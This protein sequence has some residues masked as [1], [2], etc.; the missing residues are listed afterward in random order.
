[1][2]AEHPIITLARNAPLFQLEAKLN[3]NALAALH[4]LVRRRAL[5]TEYVDLLNVHSAAER[6]I[7]ER[8]EELHRE[9]AAAPRALEIPPL[10]VTL[11]PTIPRTEKTRLV[12]PGRPVTTVPAPAPEAPVAA[13]ALPTEWERMHQTLEAQDCPTDRGVCYWR[14]STFAGWSET[15]REAAEWQPG[16]VAHFLP[17]RSRQPR[18][19]VQ[20]EDGSRRWMGGAETAAAQRSGAGQAEVHEDANCIIA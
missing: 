10:N 15:L 6:I 7:G 4:A 3:V 2:P 1:M 20:G 14:G 16:I 18:L 11:T 8:D 12:L 9:A 5:V 17:L 13:S 19:A